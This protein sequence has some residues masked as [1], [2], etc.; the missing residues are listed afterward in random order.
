[1]LI[2]LQAIDD[3]LHIPKF[4]AIYYRYRNYLFRI[5]AKLLDDQRD[6]ED[7]VQ[8]AFFAIARNIAKLDDPYSARTRA[9]ITLTIESK[10]VDILRAKKK[11]QTAALEDAS[12]LDIPMKEE[13]LAAAIAALPQRE[14]EFILLKYAQGYTNRELCGLL[15]LSYAG[16]NSLD[17]R[18]KQKLRELLKEEGIEV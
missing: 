3:P 14:R 4:T 18:A 1:M 12:G 15:G 8:E 9:Y 11:H 13:G 7:A 6:I 17:Q 16:V 2:F 10:A 5:A